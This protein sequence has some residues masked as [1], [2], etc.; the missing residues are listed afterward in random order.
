MLS[1]RDESET[2]V[3]P[4]L[5]TFSECNH[6]K[7]EML[8]KAVKCLP[9]QSLQNCTLMH[10]VPEYSRLHR[11]DFHTDPPA[12]TGASISRHG[13]D[14]IFILHITSKNRRHQLRFASPNIVTTVILTKQS[15]GPFSSCCGS[16]HMI[17]IRQME[18]SQMSWK[19]SRVQNHLTP[20]Y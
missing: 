2:S 14:L 3:T 18:F 6:E 11:D 4:P 8:Q 10:A 20:I 1:C 17:F 13:S 15:Q 9:H 16:N 7:G 12:R 19:C 5:K